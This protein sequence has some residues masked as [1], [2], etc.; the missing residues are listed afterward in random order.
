MPQT[1]FF[2]RINKRRSAH[3]SALRRLFSLRGQMP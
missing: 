1:G 3:F 2:M